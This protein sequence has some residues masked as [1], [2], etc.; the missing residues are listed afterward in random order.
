MSESR[1][2][3][4]T[5]HATELDLRKR[6]MLHRYHHAQSD[7]AAR[8]VPAL[9]TAAAAVNGYTQA[10]AAAAVNGYTQATTPATDRR[11][12]TDLFRELR[13]RHRPTTT[14]QGSR[15]CAWCS[16]LTRCSC[17]SGCI[18][19][20]VVQWPCPEVEA[21]ERAAARLREARP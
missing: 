14:H 7:I 6:A 12:V 21:F 2:L 11:I 10:T 13:L 9:R 4:L 20:A 5:R 1:R 19:S 15:A 3:R 8:L 16:D 17:D 18:H